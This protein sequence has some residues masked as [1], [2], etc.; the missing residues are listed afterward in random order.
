MQSHDDSAD[1]VADEKTD[2]GPQCIGTED[3]GKCPV[4]DGRDLCVGAE[5][6]C[7]LRLRSPVA[8]GI[9]HHL[10]G[11]FLDPRIGCTSH[12]LLL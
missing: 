11:P 3:D 12:D 6:Q 7:E 1:D 8:L 10:D 2:D 5:P 9:G 4:D